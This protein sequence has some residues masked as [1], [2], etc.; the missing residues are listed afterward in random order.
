MSGMLQKGKVLYTEDGDALEV[1][2]PELLGAGRHLSLR[3]A[4]QE[5]DLRV[6]P[7]HPAVSGLDSARQPIL[8]VLAQSR[9]LDELRRPWSSCA[10]PC[11]PLG[12]RRLVLEPERA[13]RGVAA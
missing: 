1:K 5:R 4:V 13:R 8:Y 9:V 12:D 10:A 6:R 7:E 2:L 11:V 3:S